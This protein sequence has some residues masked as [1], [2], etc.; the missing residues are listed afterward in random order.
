MGRLAEAESLLLHAEGLAAQRGWLR[1]QAPLLAERIAVALHA[2][3]K[4]AADALLLRL[5]ALSQTE[6]AGGYIAL[7]Q[8]RPYR[9]RRTAGRR[10]AAGYAGRRAGNSGEW[11]FAVRL[12][13]RQALALW[14]AGEREQ[15]MA[16]CRPALARAASGAMAQPAGGGKRWL[17]CWRRCTSAARR[18][19]R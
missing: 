14:R 5:Q 18:M 16:I 19:M 3:D 7:S 12:R 10:A 4:L 17:R 13:L 15:A 9:R 6:A 2:G 8:S 11:L 1:A